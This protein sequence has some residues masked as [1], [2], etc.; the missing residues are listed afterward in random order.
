KIDFHFHDAIGRLWQ[1][2]T[3]Q[4]DFALPERFDMEYMG[5]DN[6]RHRPVM[7][8]R[9]IL[10]SIER[11]TGVLIEHY[12][13]AFPLWLAPEQVR[14]IPIADEVKE[15]ARSVVERLQARSVRAHLDE[16]SET[17]NYRIRD[18]EV[19]KIPYMA[20]VGKREAESDS[21]ALR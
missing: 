7:I 15:F 10:G 14:V 1:L 21:I 17:L 3:I 19:H 20:V 5:E 6:E 9:A 2:T 11:F 13:G 12:A 18:G 16:R 8:H 4:C